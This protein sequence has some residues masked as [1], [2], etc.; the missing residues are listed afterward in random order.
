MGNPN[1]PNG[2]LRFY[3]K[4]YEEAF[5][6]IFKKKAKRKG[7]VALTIPKGNKKCQTRQ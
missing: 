7:G 1:I 4:E 2:E 5:N 6:N 3:N